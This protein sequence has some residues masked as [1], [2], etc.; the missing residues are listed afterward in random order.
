[1]GR[2]LGGK[3]EVEYGNRERERWSLHSG[4]TDGRERERERGRERERE[5]EGERERWKAVRVTE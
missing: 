3:R 5:R 4:L 2:T 1:V